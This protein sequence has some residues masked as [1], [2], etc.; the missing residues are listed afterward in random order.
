MAN[1][2]APLQFLKKM[3][4]EFGPMDH[5]LEKMTAGMER[6]VPDITGWTESR[7]ILAF[8]QFNDPAHEEENDVTLLHRLFEKTGPAI[9]S[10]MGLTPADALANRVN[11]YSEWSDIYMT[12]VIM[13]KWAR[14]KQVFKPDPDF[15]EALL[16]TEHLQYT[17]DTFDHLPCDVFY[18][19]LEDVP[20]FPGIHGIMVHTQMDDIFAHVNLLILAASDDPKD[21]VITFSNYG[22]INFKNGDIADVAAEEIRKYGYAFWSSSMR[23][24]DAIGKLNHMKDRMVPFL[25]AYQM[26]AYLTVEKPE[27]TENPVT[28]NT[29]RPRNPGTPVK[30]RFS[31]I[32]IHDVG[33]RYGK[34]FRKTVSEMRKTETEKPNNDAKPTRSVKP[35]FRCAHWHYHRIG[36]GRTELKL[37]WHKPVFVNGNGK[38]AETD[39]VIHKIRKEEEKPK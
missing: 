16:H 1:T 27:I 21:P 5:M 29:Y 9:L 35:H 28:K 2:Y 10:A 32:Q 33:I 23:N 12:P 8:N 17:K 38:T 7:Y 13:N 14:N 18:I 30:N 25:L 15:A 26:I 39:V 22:H 11:P 3:Q 31:E 24:N 19:D 36:K 34:D 20:A 37:M 6:L 4:D